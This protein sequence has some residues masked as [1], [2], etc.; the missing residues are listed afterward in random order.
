MKQ[1]NVYLG[2]FKVKDVQQDEVMVNGECF[3]FDP[4]MNEIEQYSG[5][6]KMRQLISEFGLKYIRVITSN[7]ISYIF[8][9]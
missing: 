9:N 3:R 7:K 5:N 2:K 6:Y 1:A 4:Q 8:T